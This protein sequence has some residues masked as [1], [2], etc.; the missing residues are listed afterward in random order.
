MIQT[1][2]PGCGSV[3]F[4]GAVLTGGACACRVFSAHKRQRKDSDA[5]WAE[6]RLPYNLPLDGVDERQLP[7]GIRPPRVLVNLIELP[8]GKEQLRCAAPHA[9]IFSTAV[10]PRA[11]ALRRCTACHSTC[12]RA[13]CRTADSWRLAPAGIR[14]STPCSARRFGHPR[15]SASSAFCI[16]NRFCA[17]FF[18]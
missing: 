17:V 18:M 1:R 11:G 4:R 5:A 2:Y 15:S 3:V 10:H 16:V 13:V 6:A 7:R 12:G 8:A 14:C 9:T